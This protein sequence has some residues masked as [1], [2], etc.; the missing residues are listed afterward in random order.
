VAD[1]VVVVPNHL[2]HLDFLAEWRDQ[3]AGTPVIVVQDVGAKPEPPAGMNVTIVD[4]GDIERDLGSDAWIIP[5]QTSACRSYGYLLA[6]R[7]RPE[8]ILTLDT[9]CYPDGSDLVAGHVANLS[10]RVTL[11][12]VNSDPGQVMYRGFP[13]AI[14][15]RS[16][17]MLSHGL[18]SG[19]PDLDGATQLHMPGLRLPPATA[20]TVIPRWSFFPMCGMNLAWRAELTPALYFGLFGPEYGF[21]QYDDIWAGVLVKRVMDHLGYAAVSGYPSVQHRKQS[22]VYVNLRKQA[23]GLAMNEQLWREVARI[24][25][26]GTTVAGCYRQLIE[27]LPDVIEDEP[28]GWTAKFRK[29]ALIWSDLF[30]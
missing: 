15:D 28:P 16:P 5:S 26:T 11:D 14:R 24:T 8:T 20:T 30:G 18:W 29:A 3:L 13:Y 6:W 12:W 23:P 10:R 9:D 1:A 17:V 7:R 25:L 27:A 22:N 19:V 4:H 21:D 2:P